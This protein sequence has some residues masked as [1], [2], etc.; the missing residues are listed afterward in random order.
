MSCQ[1]FYAFKNNCLIN[2]LHFK[3]F[4][5]FTFYHSPAEDTA[6]YFRY[7]LRQCTVIYNLLYIRI[8]ISGLSIV[9]S[10]SFGWTTF[11]KT[12]KS[13]TFCWKCGRGKLFKK[14]SQNF[15]FCTIFFYSLK[16]AVKP[17]RQINTDYGRNKREKKMQKTV[18]INECQ[19]GN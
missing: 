19:K 16:M 1:L 12:S 11:A 10:R 2:F 15:S 9:L 17:K 7:I 14:I 18:K 8:N 4:H 13:S 3:F 6:S 5:F